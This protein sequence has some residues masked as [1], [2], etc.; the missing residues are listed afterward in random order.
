MTDAN[1]YGI[2]LIFLLLFFIYS[3][4]YGD[5]TISS[6]KVNCNKILKKGDILEFTLTGNALGHVRVEIP[7]ISVKIYLSETSAGIYKG[8]YKVSG[9]T[10]SA[11][12]ASVIAC[13]EINGETCG[14]VTAGNKITILGKNP[15]FY[16]LNPSDMVIISDKKPLISAC[17]YGGTGKV[18]KKSLKLMLNRHDITKDNG[19]T[20]YNDRITFKPSENLKEGDYLIYI[21]GKSTDGHD[22]C[23]EWKFFIRLSA[24]VTSHNAI[25]ELNTGEILEVQMLGEPYQKAYFDIGEWK[26]GLP[27]HE[28]FRTP[29]LYIGTYTVQKGDSVVNATVTGYLINSSGET[30]RARADRSVSISAGE[31]LLK[32]TQPK[33]GDFVSN[34]FVVAGQTRPFTAVRI[35]VKITSNLPGIGPVDN[36]FIG[37]DIKANQGGVFEYKVKAGNQLPGSEY[38]VTVMV[39]DAQGN[40]STPGIIKVFQK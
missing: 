19:I 14:P 9:E 3:P 21:Y 36:G 5:G 1:K 20:V 29:G 23:A 38:T 7:D 32:I 12:N 4:S 15:V 34:Q 37:E 31:L 33:D 11:C 17:F 6:F 35:E 30:V 2:I 25:K 18:D 22:F 8:V 39:R 40:K 13:M 27:L 26:K 24:A 10:P 16:N 28:S